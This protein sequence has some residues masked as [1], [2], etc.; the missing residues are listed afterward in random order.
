[1]TTENPNSGVYSPP[2]SNLAII[3]LIAGILGLTLLPAIGSI[4]ALI[5]GYM[6]KKEI[7]ESRGA[8]G[9]E[10]MAKA[11]ILLGWIGI[12]LD[13]IGICFI[14]SF[15]ALGLCFIPFGILSENTFGFLMMLTSLI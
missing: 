10:G 12:V 3:S 9:G 14:G 13:V 15:V 4:V 5:I 8:L 11:G 7:E 6:A 2:N 1:M